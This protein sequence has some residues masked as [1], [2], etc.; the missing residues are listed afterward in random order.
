M[1]RSASLLTQC[2]LCPRRC[3]V[4]R[5]AGG[6]GFCGAGNNIVVAH[7]GPHFG[8]EPPISGRKGSGNIFF[9]PCNLRCIFCQNYQIS[10]TTF[11]HRLSVNDLIDVF[12]HLETAGVHNINLVS[13]TPYIPLLAR[14]IDSAKKKGI[15]I[16]FVYNTNAYE[17]V[18][19][20]RTLRGLIDIYL[21]DFKYWNNR[22]G[23]KLS[24]AP[25]YQA[26]AGHS[27]KEMKAQVGDL[28]IE[29][30]IARKGL[31]I[32]HLVLPGSLAGT[33]G[34]M[35]WIKASLGP[36]TFVSL[37]SQYYPTYKAERYPLLNRPIRRDEYESLVVFMKEEGFKNV[38]IQEPESAEL[39]L[40]DFDKAEPF[41]EYRK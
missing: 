1:D 33:K 7:W 26:W 27:I 16:P 13:P 15:K 39:L 28:S 2:E 4:D 23:A 19:S 17:N 21:P 18:D 6:H 11:G 30:G 10:Q 36:R 3:G 35:R 22:I 25:D 32:R 31:L 40:P 9:S 8:E 37:M 34:I 38:F 12:F 14:A 41:G 5:L 29:H 20:L 24:S